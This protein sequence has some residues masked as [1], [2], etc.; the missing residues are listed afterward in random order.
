MTKK[1]KE[2]KYT[3]QTKRFKMQTEK[4]TNRKATRKKVKQQE[5]KT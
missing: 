2:N 5:R 4:Q 1:Q 3:T